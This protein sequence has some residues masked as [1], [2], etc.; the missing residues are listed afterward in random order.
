MLDRTFL[1]KSQSLT[2]IPKL[3]WCQKWK[4]ALSEPSNRY[5]SGCYPLIHCWQK[6]GGK[7]YFTFQCWT[8][9]FSTVW[10]PLPVV[11][12][13]KL[14]KGLPL[15]Y[16]HLYVNA[17]WFIMRVTDVHSCW[18]LLAPICEINLCPSMCWSRL[19]V[20][21][22]V[23]GASSSLSCLPGSPQGL[24]GAVTSPSY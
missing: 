6:D 7:L 22:P 2:K 18:P 13:T 8:C 5:I 20:L 3:F 4:V 24:I 14:H 11:I 23:I 10:R 12:S 9:W 21:Q 1:E 19:C 16:W 17:Q 15:I